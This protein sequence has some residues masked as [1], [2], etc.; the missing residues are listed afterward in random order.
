[1]HIKLTRARQLGNVVVVCLLLACCS[2]QGPSAARGLQPSPKPSASV[3][4]PSARPTSTGGTPEAS[5]QVS[6]KGKAPSARP[7]TSAASG[8]APKT[9]LTPIGTEP[10]YPNPVPGAKTYAYDEVERSSKQG[11]EL[12]TATGTY[13][14]VVEPRKGNLQRVGSA[15]CCADLRWNTLRFEPSQIELVSIGTPSASCS[16]EPTV[17]YLQLPLKVGAHWET[18][19]DCV[20]ANGE[21]DRFSRS[22]TIRSVSRKFVSGYGTLELWRIATHLE[23]YPVGIPNMDKVVSDLDSDFCPELLVPVSETEVKSTFA[24][25]EEYA[26]DRITRTLK[27]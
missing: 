10:N 12:P 1:L 24:G 5:Q 18:A 3:V 2:R 16:F 9:G 23:V 8:V 26:R 15:P 25:N 17:I 22:T 6:P 4:A 19:G 13:H 14:Y 21:K 27:T 7:R 11:T 20:Y